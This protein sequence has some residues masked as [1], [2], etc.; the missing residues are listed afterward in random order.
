MKMMVK[1]QYQL[2]GHIYTVVLDPD[3]EKQGDLGAT[4]H[5]GQ[6]I[7]INPTR[8][9]SQMFEA[10]IHELFHVINVVFVHHDLAEH[11]IGGLAQG[12]LQ[13]L[14][15][16]GIELDWSDVP[17]KSNELIDIREE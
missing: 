13:L 4:D 1:K 17:Y 6:R 10:L 2:G 12:T 14:S 11:H 3:L 8:P 15:Q 7:Y 5:I 9:K 16:H